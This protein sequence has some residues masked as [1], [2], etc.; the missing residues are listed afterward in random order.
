MRILSDVRRP[1]VVPLADESKL[2]DRDAPAPPPAPVPMLGLLSVGRELVS[3]SWAEG[4]CLGVTTRGPNA[5]LSRFL[6][7][8]GGVSSR[9]RMSRCGRKYVGSGSDWPSRSRGASPSS[10]A[11]S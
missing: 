4:A 9:R 10:S 6:R 1:A 2:T 3:P 7:W 11:H 8:P 5:R